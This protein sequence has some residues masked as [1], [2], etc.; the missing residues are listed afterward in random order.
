MK[1]KTLLFNQNLYQD[2][3]AY[4]KLQAVEAVPSQTQ[5]HLLMLKMILLRWTTH[6]IQILQRGYQFNFVKKEKAVEI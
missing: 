5:L 3:V 2:K 4:K 6:W 1:W